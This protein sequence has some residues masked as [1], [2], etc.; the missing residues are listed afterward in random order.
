[1]AETKV[2]KLL[3]DV[4]MEMIG[5]AVE[6]YLRDSKGM[7]T[8][9]GKTTEGYIVQGKQEADMW[10]K[11]SGTEQAI[12]VQMF[13]SGD[14]INITAGFGKWSDKIGAGIVGTFIAFAPLAFTAAIGAY[15][16]KKLPGE[17]FDFIEKF[18]LSGGQSA[19]VGVSGGKM[20]S[21]DEVICKECK[22]SNPKGKKFCSNCGAKL[23][24]QCP[25][26]QADV[27][28]GVKFCPECGA[29]MVVEHNCPNC[30]TSYGEG[31][32]FCLEC[33]QALSE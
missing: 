18:I 24:Q 1:M 23:M 25:N 19:A 7:I 12:T 5:E 28:D 11:I 8:Q 33:G 16:Q 30:G 4:T 27:A 29:S 13:Q 9:A 17:I 32:K 6:G 3:N 21:D 31:Q 2:F 10:K 15:M 26:C 20:L 14:I 22:T